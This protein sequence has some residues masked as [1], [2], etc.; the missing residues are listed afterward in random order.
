MAAAR[1]SSGVSHAVKWIN[2]A[3][4]AEHAVYTIFTK[5][6]HILDSLLLF[7]IV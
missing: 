1:L 2:S 7:Y 4:A 5:T 6:I 3:K